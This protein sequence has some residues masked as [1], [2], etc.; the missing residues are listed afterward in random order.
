MDDAISENPKY[1]GYLGKLDS[2]YIGYII[3]YFTYSSYKASSI[4]HIEDLFIIKNFR[5]KGFGKKLFDF[6]IEKTKENGCDHIEWT[7]YIWNKPAIKFFEKNKAFPSDKYYYQL[8]IE[9]K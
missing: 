9:N 2:K 4:L 5:K 3:F 8:D 1:Y 7:T 6:C